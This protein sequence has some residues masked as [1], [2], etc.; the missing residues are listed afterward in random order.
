MAITFL[1]WNRA[2][3]PP[4]L[5]LP[6]TDF[7][8]FVLW[9]PI[10]GESDRTS[11]I[12]EEAGPG[13]WREGKKVVSF[14][15]YLLKLLLSLILLEM[16]KLHTYLQHTY[17]LIHTQTTPRWDTLMVMLMEDEAWFFG[18]MKYNLCVSGV[19]CVSTYNLWLNWKVWNACTHISSNSKSVAPDSSVF[20]TYI[21]TFLHGPGDHYQIFEV[22]VL[23]NSKNVLATAKS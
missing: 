5:S 3:P 23:A 21:L 1:L 10:H 22:G 15:W 11:R 4:S 18:R 14:P 9:Q 2:P 8:L 16:E 7:M 12:M 19:C 13:L 6:R 20:T 17:S